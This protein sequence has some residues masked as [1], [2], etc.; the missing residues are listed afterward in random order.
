MGGVDIADFDADYE[1]AFVGAM[2]A[3]LNNNS[4]SGV[5]V[6]IDSAEDANVKRR[7]LEGSRV[8]VLYHIEVVMEEYGEDA[9]SIFGAIDN[10]LM[11]SV[12]SS[13]LTTKMSNLLSQLK[14][15]S[16]SVPFDGI[17]N[18]EDAMVLTLLQS[19]APSPSPSEGV[20]DDTNAIITIIIISV[21]V[22]TCVVL[23]GGAVAY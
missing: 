16:L 6:I 4:R 11:K 22:I 9:S 2:E 3:S 12:L 1:S 14:N 17:D 7:L 19:A 20:D 13:A 23:V 10:M 15:S 21:I 5:I 8:R 18:D